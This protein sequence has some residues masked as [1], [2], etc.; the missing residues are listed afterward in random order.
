MDAFKAVLPHPQ[1]VCAESEENGYFF[2]P[3]EKT[4]C[5]WHFQYEALAEPKHSHRIRTLDINFD[6]VRV[7]GNQVMWV[8]V[9]NCRFFTS[10]FPML[11]TLKSESDPDCCDLHVFSTRPFP[12]TLRSLSYRASWSMMITSLRNLTSFVFGTSYEYWWTSIEDVREFMLN[13]QTL[14]SLEFKEIYLMGDPEGPPVELPNLKSLIIGTLGGRLSTIIRVPTFRRLSS[15]QVSPRCD[16]NE[17]VLY[18]TGDGVTLSVTCNSFECAGTWEDF[19][20]YAA[21]VI[22]TSASKTG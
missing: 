9:E 10:S 5:E 7:D 12:P 6:R 14:E 19:T 15:L 18:A 16:H 3:N 22:A 8:S 13:N 20:G 1:C 17:Y 2:R 4:P 11:A 21:P